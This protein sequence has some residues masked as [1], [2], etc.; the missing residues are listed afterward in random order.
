ME[1]TFNSRALP[2]L[3][4]D[5]LV[6][7]GGPAGVA[8]AIGAAR[9][10][11]NTLLIEA[12]GALGGMGTH[13]LIPAWCPFSDKEKI[14]Y[15]GVGE[16]VFQALKGLMPHVP[17]GLNDWAPIDPE[18]LKRLYDQFVLESGAKVL[19]NVFAVDVQK[20]GDAIDYVV[21]AGKRGLQ[22]IRAKVY[23]DGTGD[24]DIAARAG[25]Q[26]LNDGKVQPSTHCFQ[27]GNVD[28]YNYSHVFRPN[29]QKV[30]QAI[31][32]CGRYPL[33]P[34]RHFC[35]SI[36]ANGL[37]GF[38]AGH[39]FDVD[40]TDPQSVT[41]ALVLGRKQAL[42]FRDALAEFAPETFGA[43][44]VAQTAPLM[45]IRESR[46]VLCDYVLSV[47]DYFARRSFA[48][49]IGRNCYF[50]DIH[51]YA[52]EAGAA[53]S[54]ELD[55][56]KRYEHL[57]AGESHGIPYRILTAKGLSNLLVAGRTVST[58][59]PVNASMRV[60]PPCFVTGE[61]AGVAAAMAAGSRNVR[62]VNVDQLRAALRSAGG[63]L[64]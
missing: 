34:D 9:A 36:T 29:S 20:T 37:I 64:P 33:I 56:T 59:H 55:I 5:V 15:G 13:G 51:N 47:D 31:L 10:G 28:M 26:M 11:A 22:A 46:R 45:G 17:K 38:N 40:A 43:S 57:K 1:V 50:I 4:V 21:V 44:Y 39:V 24:A 8:A 32:D 2:V 12:T 62:A 48:D 54:G 18:A 30:L 42:A 41:D 63:Y 14:I 35:N 23:V 3:D 16:R 6:A 52:D 49:E 19:F 25:A 60:M 27:L 7:G 61:A 58:D 53:K